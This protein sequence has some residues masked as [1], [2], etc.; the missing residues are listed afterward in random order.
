MTKQIEKLETAQDFYDFFSVI[1]DEKWL[2]CSFKNAKGQACASGHLDNYVVSGKLTMILG[3]PVFYI[4]DGKDPRYSQSHPKE[5]V[6]AALKD[7][8]ATDM[9]TVEA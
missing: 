3:Q 5:R 9:G 1:P 6:L 7:A 2:A 4:N 8:G